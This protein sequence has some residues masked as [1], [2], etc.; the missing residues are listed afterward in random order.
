MLKLLYHP[1]LTCLNDLAPWNIREKRLTFHLRALVYGNYSSVVLLVSVSSVQSLSCVRL[2]ETPWIAARQT[3]LSITNSRRLLK[4]MSIESVM[5][6]NH[7]ILCCP[8]LLLPS[9]FPSLRVFS[10]ELVLH[11]R[12]PKYWRFSFSINPSNEYSG[13]I[14]IYHKFH[15]FPRW[16]I[17]TSGGK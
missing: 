15:Y 5:P 1:T 8:L 3:S 4:L 7:L 11:I 6:S 16:W 10:N 9:I 12:W 14:Y 17:N 13:L 2:F